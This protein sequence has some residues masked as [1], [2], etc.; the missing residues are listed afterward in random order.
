MFESPAFANLRYHKRTNDWLEVCLVQGAE[1]ALHKDSVLYAP[2]VNTRQKVVYY[3]LR[4]LAYICPFRHKACTSVL[5]ARARG[6]FLC[7]TEP[8]RT[9][10]HG[11]TVRGETIDRTIPRPLLPVRR[12]RRARRPAMM[13]PS[14]RLSGDGVVPGDLR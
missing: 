3:S 6:T 9:I 8:A 7:D 11:S 1:A 2:V 14:P 13:V 4:H 12:W 10:A 5:A